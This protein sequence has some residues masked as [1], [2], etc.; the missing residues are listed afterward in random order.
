MPGG[1]IDVEVG[2]ERLESDPQRVRR[3]LLVA[4]V[5][6]ERRE[7]E[8][9]LDVRQRRAHPHAE[10]G[11]EPRPRGIPRHGRVR[12]ASRG[13]RAPGRRGPPRAAA[14]DPGEEVGPDRAVRE[15]RRPLD[16]VLELADVARPAVLE[17]PGACLGC[18]DYAAGRL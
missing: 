1:A 4:L 15:D 3:S 9:P 18:D 7:D 8:P 13:S 6:R 2:V 10:R 17:E 14:P 12:A 16:R 11:L 5:L